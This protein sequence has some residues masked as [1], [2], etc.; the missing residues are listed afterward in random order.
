MTYL[1]A[2]AGWGSGLYGFKTGL[3]PPTPN[4]RGCRSR[5]HKGLISGLFLRVPEHKKLI[6]YI[7]PS[8]VRIITCPRIFNVALMVPAGAPDSLTRNMHRKSL[9][10]PLKTLLPQ[11]LRQKLRKPE[12]E[13]ESQEGL[14]PNEMIYLRKFKARI[15]GLY[16]VV[17]AAVVEASSQQ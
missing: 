11:T 2:L 17:V 8:P 5:Q 6:Q 9:P 3:K 10:C 7:S 15:A 4:N 1:K 16:F 14:T 12:S 13:E